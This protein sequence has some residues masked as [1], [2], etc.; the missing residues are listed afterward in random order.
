MGIIYIPF[1]GGGDWRL[2]LAREL[3][4]AGFPVDMNKAL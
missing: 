2:I 3:K 4:T 1:D